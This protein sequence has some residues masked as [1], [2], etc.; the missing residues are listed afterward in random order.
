[1]DPET[2]AV[3]VIDLQ[4]EHFEEDRPW[5]VPDSDRVPDQC[6]RILDAAL[7]TEATVVHARDVSRAR[8]AAV[9]GGD[10]S[11]SKSST[12]SSMCCHSIFI[13]GAGE[14]FSSLRRMP[15]YMQHKQ[16]EGQVVLVTGGSSGIGA[17]TARQFA[18]AGANVVL[19]ARSE[20]RLSA[21]A[22]ACRERGVDALA[23]PTD[24]T[25]PDAVSALVE[26]TEKRFG[27]LDVTVANAGTSEQ[28]DVPLSELPL[29]QFEQVTET[30][31]HG[32]YYTT[33][34]AAPL[35]RDGG[36]A[37]VFVGSFKGK[38]PST[39]TPIY[40]ASKWWL[41][42]FAASMAGRL[43]PDGVGVS[44]INPSGVT[45][46]FGSQF[47]EQTNDVVLSESSTLDAEDVAGAIR[48]VAAQEPPATV[49]ELDLNRRDIFARF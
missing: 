34:A 45:T 19:C 7:E 25:D 2:T 21:V 1:M 36:G 8:D 11:I 49:S 13:S 3:I 24:I 43:G 39:S 38:Y 26:A 14:S 9:F 15:V 12:M 41:R 46:N 35:L 47:R 10:R 29:E 16:F 40:A 23:V 22:A 32:A 31:V 4:R 18:D 20:D 27:R 5:Y 33:R 48:Y 28:S 44:L 30:N 42:G 17:A 6:R 37:L